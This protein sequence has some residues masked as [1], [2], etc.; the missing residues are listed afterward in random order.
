MREQP[1]GR[2][3]TEGLSTLQTRREHLGLVS[4]S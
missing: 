4:A 3:F 1:E 2:I